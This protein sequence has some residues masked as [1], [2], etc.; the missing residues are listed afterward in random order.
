MYIEGIGIN[1]RDMEILLHKLD[2]HNFFH[3]DIAIMAYSQFGTNE[4]FSR[5]FTLQMIR[6]F[7]NAHERKKALQ[8]YE[9]PPEINQQILNCRTFTPMIFVP[10]FE[11][12]LED[13]IYRMDPNYSAAEFVSQYRGLSKA[14]IE[15]TRMTIISTFEKA[16]DAVGKQSETT[17]FFRHIRNAAAHECQFRLTKAVLDQE[18]GNLK[19][20]AKWN[21][22][23]ITYK[24][25]GQRLLPK[26]RGDST[27]FWNQGDFIEFLLDFENHHP[28]IKEN[29]AQTNKL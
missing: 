10:A 12:I 24:N 28:E 1:L 4:L 14:N 17:E 6:N 20:N 18:T 27:A 15:I 13:K 8:E 9:F 16:M 26:Q 21:S 7:P 19:K 29:Y 23:E 5:G 22:F 3:K 11:T 25:Q 2:K